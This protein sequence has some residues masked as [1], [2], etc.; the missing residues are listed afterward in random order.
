MESLNGRVARIAADHRSGA[1]ELVVEVISLLTDALGSGA[2]LRPLAVSLVN[3]QPSMAPVW[4][5]VRAALTA[6]SPTDFE[7]YVE[8]TRR[9]PRSLG[10]HAAELLLT[11]SSA[12]L[13]FVTISFSGTVAL[14][15]ES[16]VAARPLHVACADGLPG[17]EGRRMTAQLAAAGIPVSHFTDAALAHAVDAADAVLVGADA[18]T[19]DWFLN[20]SG[21]RMLAAAAAQQGIPVYVLATRDKFLS[22]GAAALLEVREE[23]PAEVWPSPPAGVTVRNP[24]FEATTLD[25]VSAVISDAGVLGA[26]LVP[27]ACPTAGDEILMGLRRTPA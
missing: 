7:R 24:Y 16:L 8:Q 3:A 13:K 27:D 10:R 19:P 6:S 14:V 23:S 17:L 18:V 21:T 12:P 1:S 26:A 20:K 11:G 9:A 22:R 5:A 15:L 2:P 4:N 25:L